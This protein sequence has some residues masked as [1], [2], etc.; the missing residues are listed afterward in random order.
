M[1]QSASPS[2]VRRTRPAARPHRRRL[3]LLLGVAALACLGACGYF[4][5][6]FWKAHEHWN[7]ALAHL[8]KGE[9]REARADLEAYLDVWPGSPE[10]HFRLAR[11]CRRGED[12]AAARKHLDAADKAG[13]PRDDIDLELLLNDVQQNGPGGME[14][15]ALMGRA[16][17]GG[18]EAP[19]VL[20]AIAVGFLRAN[21]PAQAL[22]AMSYWTT[23]YPDDWRAWRLRADFFLRQGFAGFARKDFEKVVE[24]RPD[25]LDS[26][27]YLA[28]MI[29]KSGSDFKLAADGFET[30][31]RS[32]PNETTALAGLARCQ[33]ALN[34]TEAAR[35]T[36]DRLF[37]LE[38]D[39][40]SGLLTLAWLQTDDDRHQDALNTLRRLENVRLSDLE[41]IY[42]RTHLLALAHRALGHEQEAT[43]C[44]RQMAGLKADLADLNTSSEKLLMGSRDLALHRKIGAIYLRMGFEQEGLRWLIGL[45]KEDP[46]DRETNQLLLDY[47]QKRTDPESK[48]RA[49]VH[50]R[51]LAGEDP[52]GP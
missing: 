29:L 50:R 12:F 3:I 6:R 51:L 45:L 16:K 2:A 27:L 1:G 11:V 47:Y 32:R 36:L 21:R 9:L 25:D 5:H 33:R 49:E 14:L 46:K 39:N 37:A 40:S 30:V 43:A 41:E 48:R 4:G 18:P 22:G 10:G 7:R 44:E 13:W 35:K 38:P 24:L 28:T 15:E 42:T 20:E 23:Q 19:Y 31:L 52:P 17:A 8:D 26:R 34:Q